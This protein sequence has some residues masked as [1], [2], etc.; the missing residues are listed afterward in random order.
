MHAD[1]DECKKEEERHHGYE[2]SQADETDKGVADQHWKE[3]Q[4]RGEEGCREQR[5]T[6]L[7]GV[8][9][10]VSKHERETREEMNSEE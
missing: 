9:L 3:V 5:H 7:R 8:L 2:P 6:H 10:S 4:P 1:K